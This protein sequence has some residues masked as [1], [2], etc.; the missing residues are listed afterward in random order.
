MDDGGYE[1]EETKTESVVVDTKKS[2]TGTWSK[3]V[4]IYLWKGRRRFLVQKL[5][6]K[7]AVTWYISYRRMKRCDRSW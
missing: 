2:S 1:E 7:F 4:R 5:T 3:E 6:L